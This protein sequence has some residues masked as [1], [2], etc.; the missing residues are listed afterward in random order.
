MFGKLKNRMR[1]MAT[2]K[3]L[4]LEAERQARQSG[5][6]E[7]GAEHFLL[8]AIELP[9]GTAGRAFARL[10]ISPDSVR[11]AIA[12]QYNDALR[13]IGVDPTALDAMTQNSPVPTDLRMLYQAKPSGARMMQA[14]AA[15]RDGS[16]R[17]LL[18]AHVVAVIAEMEEGVAA[19]TLRAM[20]VDPVALSA[21]ALAEAGSSQT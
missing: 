18:G 14:L 2:I 21:A 5:E 7:P 13:G 3:A 1:D 17:P 10:G 20:G 15:L 9:D 8:S 19:R 12:T 6:S 4:C 11:A 16:E